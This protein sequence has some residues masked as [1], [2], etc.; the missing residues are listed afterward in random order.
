MTVW[1]EW[2]EAPRADFGVI[3]DPISHSRSPAMH[4][5]AYAACG[6]AHTYEAVRVPLAEFSEAVTHLIELGYLGLNCT[7]PLKE[8]AATWCEDSDEFSSVIGAI[9]TIDL[10]ARRGTNTDAPAFLNVLQASGVLTAAK[11]L[12]LGAGGTARAVHAALAKAEYIASGWNRTAGKLEAIRREMSLDFSI[13]ES[14]SVDGFDVVVNTTSAGLVGEA[15]PLHWDCPNPPILA[16]DVMYGMPSPFLDGAA[17]HRIAIVDGLP[18]L[19]EQGALAFE[20]WLGIPAPRT[21][22]LAAVR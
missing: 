8:A 10:P 6:I 11:V 19:V 14:P 13:L 2:R 5:A 20:W 4:S 22:M 7:V 9:N 1:Y 21:D 17:K 18:L 12:V 15:P 3:G 16:I